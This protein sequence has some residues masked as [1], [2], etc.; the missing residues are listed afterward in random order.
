MTFS[1]FLD[2]GLSG[3]MIVAGLKAAVEWPGYTEDCLMPDGVTHV[4]IFPELCRLTHFQ[5]ESAL[6]ISESG[7]ASVL[8]R[9][10]VILLAIWQSLVDPM[11]NPI[12]EDF[13]S[14]LTG[15][16]KAS[17]NTNGQ[18]FYIASSRCRIWSAA[19]PGDS[20]KLGFL[21]VVTAPGVYEV[22]CSLNWADGIGEAVLVELREAMNCQ[23]AR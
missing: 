9:N 17:S 1:P 22:K 19:E 11:R 3:P 7:P 13:D 20:I 8:C 21:E 16:V 23:Q 18:T 2:T 10:G 5:S 14:L 4:P 12:F 6:L 15:T